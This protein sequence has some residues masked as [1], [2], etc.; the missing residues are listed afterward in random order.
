MSNGASFAF[1][2]SDADDIDVGLELERILGDTEGN[3][4]G[5]ELLTM[6]GDDEGT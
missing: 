1:S 5:T 3:S 6:L 2:H 4:D